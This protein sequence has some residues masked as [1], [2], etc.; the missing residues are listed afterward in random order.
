MFPNGVPMDRD[1]PSPEPL[2]H[3]FLYVC[4]SPQKG[5][6]LHTYGEKHKVT[7]HRALRRQ[8]AYVQWG[9]A[10]FP[11]DHPDV[12]VISVSTETS[13]LHEKKF[14]FI[15]FLLNIMY[16]LHTDVSCST[17]IFYVNMLCMAK[18]LFYNKLYV[19]KKTGCKQ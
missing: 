13:K 19:K 10:W 18:N 14:V 2:V 8:K 6:V 1:T 11:T 17:G 5:A 12:T 3:S 7:I 15:P 9:A 16:I 4:R